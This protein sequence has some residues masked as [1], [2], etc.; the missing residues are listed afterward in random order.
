[1][2]EDYPDKTPDAVILDLGNVVLNW[3]VEGILASL[4]LPVEIRDHLREE[5][6]HHQDW[7]D[8]D[9]G[10]TTESEVL[11]AIC[12]RSPLQPTQ[13]EATLAATKQSMQ[14]LADTIHL[15]REIHEAG[16]PMYCLSNMSRES[17]A[18]VSGYDFFEM[19]T[20]IVISGHELCMKPD[21]SIFHLILERFELEAEAT[22]FVDDSLPNIEAARHLG[23]QAFH[24]KRSPACYS[25]LREMLF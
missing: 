1:M 9:H 22:L 6:F 11:D 18:H 8:L 13:V 24:F 2:R 10:T 7:L 20:G 3:D 14:P 19:F 25:S 21:H 4:D 5:L 23:I 17:Y 16:L 12:E 15:M